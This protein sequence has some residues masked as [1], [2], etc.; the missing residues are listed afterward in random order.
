MA[1]EDRI[2]SSMD[3][4]LQ[5]LMAD[6]T[7]AAREHAAEQVAD[8]ESRLRQEFQDQIEAIAQ[9]ERAQATEQARAEFEGEMARAVAEARHDADG[10]LQAAVADAEARASAAAVATI[11]AARASE[12]ELEMAGLARL[13]ESIRG[14][15]GASSLSEVLDA[16]ALAAARETAR[17]AVV[18]LKGDHVVGWRLS[19]FGPR[20]AQPKS[21]DL[22]MVESGVIGIAAATSRPATTRDG[23]ADGPGFEHLPADRMGLAL[24]VIVGGR[25]VAVVY[26]DGV[27]A[28]GGEHTVPSPWPE[29]IEI[30]ARHAGRCLE[31][32]TAQKV[33]ASTSPAARRASSVPEAAAIDAGAQQGPLG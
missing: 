5:A 12:R 30:L 22:P 25:V 6:V 29:A 2:R 18:V 31:A 14:L 16:L 4:A 19:G 32:L 8:A 33:T 9:S 21:V 15:D 23:A 20:D 3:Q 10:R 13:V 24:P 1:L 17:A 26:A 28:N 7:T 27:T 11:T